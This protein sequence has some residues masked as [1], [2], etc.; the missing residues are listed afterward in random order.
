LEPRL[1][2]IA[3][4]SPT[5]TL[6]VYVKKLKIVGGLAAICALAFSASANSVPTRTRSSYGD[7]IPPVQSFATT[8]GPD[9][10]EILT[11]SFCADNTINP[12]AGT[13]ELAFSFQI[14]SP[15]PA[16]IQT[17]SF[18]LPVPE[19]TSLLS[20]TL[21]TN[22]SA[23]ILTS[24][25]GDS[26]FPFSP[27]LS[28]AILT[29]LSANAVIAGLN[30]GQPTFTFNF[31]DI[32]PNEAQNLA[33]FMEVTDNNSINHDGMFCY[34]VGT[35]TQPPAQGD[36]AV[37]AATDLPTLPVPAVTVTTSVVP[38]PEPASILMLGSG[39]LGLVGFGRRRRA[40]S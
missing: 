29:S 8:P 19:N 16:G 13:C 38:A 35:N 12:G 10:L 14:M 32:T 24:D 11:K 17:L 5:L 7:G 36:P 27:N 1:R 25:N 21:P 2:A 40:N 18:T 20:S 6:G 4:G 30:G 39:L 3:R 34:Q 22:V 28:S 26:D 15:L 37:C 23:G 33:L 9:G 31:P